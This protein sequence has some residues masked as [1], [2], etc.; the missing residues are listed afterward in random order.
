MTRSSVRWSY[1]RCLVD[2][3]IF[4]VNVK[5]N[6]TYTFSR[7]KKT[8]GEFFWDFLFSGNFCAIFRFLFVWICHSYFGG[9][10]IVIIP[11]SLY[12]I[13]LGILEFEFF[14]SFRK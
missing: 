8:S 6:L 12:L 2:F 13:F 5:L 10:V 14:W 3:L 11:P 7:S 4:S 9:L 1:F